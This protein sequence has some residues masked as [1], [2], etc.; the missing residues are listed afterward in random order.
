M[1]KEAKKETNPACNTRTI[2][3]FFG[4]GKKMNTSEEWCTDVQQMLLGMQW[5]INKTV[6]M[7]ELLKVNMWRSNFQIL[8]SS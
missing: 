5:Q 1:N 3:S 7:T 6:K 4:L 8:L 2:R